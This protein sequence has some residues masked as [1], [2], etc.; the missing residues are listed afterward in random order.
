M[1]GAPGFEDSIQPFF[2]DSLGLRG[3]LVRLGDAYES[4]VAPHAYPQAVAEIMGEALAL[5]SALA[6]GLKFDGTF[7]LQTRSDGPVDVMVA[8]FTDAG[9][10]RGYARLDPD[11]LA[12]SRASAPVPRLLG[13]GHLAFTVDQ[14]PETERYQGIAELVGP[15]LQASAHNYFERSEQLATAVELAARS[16]PG[17]SRA[18]ALIIQR[19]PGIGEDSDEAWRRSVALLST[20]KIGEL[21]DPGLEPARLLHRLYAIEGLRLGQ[22]RPLRWACRCSRPRIGAMLASFPPTEILALAEDGRVTVTCEFCKAE[23]PFTVAEVEHFVPA[24]VS[25]CP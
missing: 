4:V 10:I 1:S 22:P 15:T 12:A 7:I 5:A 23:Y 20:V 18:A 2:V 3:R 19:L 9:E 21:L 13:A 6:S 8:Q 24:P 17:A 25:P 11:K 16:A 14:G